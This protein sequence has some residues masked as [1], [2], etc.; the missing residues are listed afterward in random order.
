M[1]IA[2]LG[3]PTG[4]GTGSAAT[5]LTATVPTAVQGVTST[6]TLLLW[7]IAQVTATTAVDIA[8]PSGWS[9]WQASLTAG[10]N[11]KVITFYRYA[12]AEPTSYALSGLTSA[13]YAWNIRAYSGVD[14][15]TPQDVT[16]TN[17]ISATA[18]VAPAAI[19]PVTSGAWIDCTN[20][21]ASASA[22]TTT[23]YTSSNMTKDT[24]YTS[25]STNT[26]NAAGGTAHLAWT[27]GAFTPN[28]TQATST[29][30]RGISITSAIRPSIE[31]VSG[32]LATSL[33]GVILVGAGTVANPV[34]GTMAATLT[35][36]TLAASGTSGN[37]PVTGT[38][39]TT[40]AGATLAASGTETVTGTLAASLSGA[41]L[42]G[43]G[44]EKISGTLATT[45]GGAT[46]AATGIETITGTLTTTLSGAALSAIA[47]E[48]M[49]GVLA[50]TLAGAMLAATG[51]V[52]SGAAAPKAPPERT[53]LAAG[54]SHAGSVTGSTRTIP[55]SQLTRKATAT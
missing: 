4:G 19:T 23:T 51:T 28:L 48:R 43:A 1:A 49:S 30:S 42:A 39:A 27:S 16:P 12:S 41:T 18:M 20:A 13:R 6:T 25:T 21:V 54:L 24:D 14:A 44:T 33:T 40:L 11:T 37:A 7:T 2:L 9:S 55:A 8:T 3:T 5:S 47:N 17:V 10:T 32:A 29:A 50:A 31:A 38:L 36:A 45:L 26:S 52:A 35:G 53:D 46:L 15:T 22:I 34:T